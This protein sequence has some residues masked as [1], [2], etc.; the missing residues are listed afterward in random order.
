MAIMLRRSLWSK[1]HRY[2]VSFAPEKH[3]L[4]NDHGLVVIRWA[5]F[6]LC[7]YQS[8]NQSFSLSIECCMMLIS[9]LILSVAETDSGRYDCLYNGQLVSSFH[10]AVDSHRLVLVWFW[11]N[12]PIS[13][14][15]HIFTSQVFGSKQDCR[16]PED[17][18]WLV[19]N[20]KIS[21]LAKIH[22]HCV[23]ENLSHDIMW[24]YGQTTG[25]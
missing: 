5:R 6:Y 2:T 7:S 12:F 4:T 24:Y 9:N 13:L 10:I 25:K 16:L 20:D 17:L 8:Q 18:Q 3:V 23:T 14:F 22:H 15:F 21:M 11:Q 19:R 1:I